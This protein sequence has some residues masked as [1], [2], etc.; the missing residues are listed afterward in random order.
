MIKDIDTVR[1]IFGLKVQ[2]LRKEKGLSYQQLSNL[3]GLAISYLHNIEKGKKYPKADKIIALSKALDTEY[4]YLV[5][6]EADKKLQPIID[7]LQSEFLQ[8]FPLELFGINTTKLLEL[9]AHTPNKV[10]AFVSTILKITRNY[11]LQ[12]EDFYQ[13]ALRSFQDMHE[14]YF[15]DLEKAVKELRQTFGL[16][17]DQI[18]DT[19]TLEQL[20]QKGYGVVV[21]RALLPRNNSLKRIRSYYSPSKKTLFVNDDLES[22]QENFLLAKE[23][24]FQFM[25][26][27]ERTYETRMLETESFDKLLNNFRASYFADALLMDEMEIVKDV[28]EMAQW[29]AWDSAAFLGLLDKYDVTPEMLLQRLANILPKHFGIK[30]L[31]FIRFFTAPDLQKF[32][33]TK[34]MHLSKLH[35]PHANQLD[36]HYCRRWISINL[37]RRLKAAQSINN[38]KGPI[39]GAQISRYNHNATPS[40]YLCLCVAKPS[41]L[42]PEFS[43]SVTIGLL[44][45]EK[46]KRLFRFLNDPELNV[47]DVHTTCE[48]CPI[49]DCG[50]RAVPPGVLQYEKRKDEIKKS[51]E[52]IE[53]MPYFQI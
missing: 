40:S 16:K 15:E 8:L 20:L 27:E 26:F 6:L 50:A 14:N 9:L 3:T 18:L 29:E 21:D 53:K 49:L 37:V 39:A 17:Q 10:N 43:T 31:F 34:E 38:H 13:T 25:D 5:S 46:L 12:G 19:P 48:R 4:D 35:T 41:R 11:H 45:N 51:L 30:E 1:L 52:A 44:I 23:L 36:E 7:L 2:S 32:E 22:A 28:F 33:M 24:A 42:D 47:K